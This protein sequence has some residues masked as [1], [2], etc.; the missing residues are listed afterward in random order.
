M[1]GKMTFFYFYMVYREEKLFYLKYK[2]GYCWDKCLAIRT[3]P[4]LF[5]GSW[6]SI[7]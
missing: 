7:I 6:P 2:L 5:H 4:K 1:Y 3:Q